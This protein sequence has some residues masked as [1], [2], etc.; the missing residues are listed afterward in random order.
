MNNLREKWFQT[1]LTAVL[2]AACLT[3]IAPLVHL[4]AVSLSSAR[5]ADAGLVGFWPK[6]PS[7]NVYRTIVG[8]RTLWR[9]MGVSIYITV[10]GTAAALALASSLAFALSRPA[11]PLKSWFL[12][13]IIVTLVFSIPLIPGYLVIKALSM[14]NTLWALIVPGALSAFNVIIMRTFFLGI[15]SEL[16][17]AAKIDGSG[18]F[19]LY[20]NVVLRLSGPVLATIAL[21]HAVGQWNQYFAPLIYIRDKSLLPLQVLLRNL[22]VES[23]VNSMM[24][25]GQI[26]MSLAATPEMMKAGIVIFATVPILIVYPFL[27]KYFVKGAM[28]GSLKE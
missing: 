23:D 14:E 10:A 26:Q 20:T 4:L 17:D 12:R 16:F 21:F 18:E 7:L 8:M 1:G 19:G 25:S 28:L 5:Y 3:M 15:S 2:L 22:V 24:Q 6:E 13:G 9:S 11:M 27:Q